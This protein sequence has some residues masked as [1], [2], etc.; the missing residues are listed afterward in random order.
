PNQVSTSTTTSI[1]G[2]LKGSGGN[3][4]AAVAGTDYVATN[5]SRLTNSR[6]PTTHATSHQSGGSDAI[7]LDDLSTPDDKLKVGC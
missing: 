1:S 7:K 5:D 4:A 2:L 6:T 3:V